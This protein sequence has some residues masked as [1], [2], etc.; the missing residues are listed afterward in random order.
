MKGEKTRR[1]AFR[2]LGLSGAGLL[3]DAM[4]VGI[5]SFVLAALSIQWGLTPTEMGLVGTVNFIG[6][7]LGAALAGML[8]DRYGRKQ[9]FI[10]TLL[11]Y[12]VATGANAW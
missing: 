2:L 7:A 3:F 9:L 1:D 4:D 5:L 6:M 8:A 12:S 10:A 11:I